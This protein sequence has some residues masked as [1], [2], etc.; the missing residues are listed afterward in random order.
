M[1]IPVAEWSAF[2]LWSP[3]ERGGYFF[4]YRIR[5]IEFQ[6]PNIKYRIELLGFD[7]RVEIIFGC[8][9]WYRVELIA[10]QISIG[11]VA[12]FP[13]TGQ[14]LAPGFFYS[15]RPPVQYHRSSWDEGI[16]RWGV[17]TAA[18]ILIKIIIVSWTKESYCCCMLLLLW[19]YITVLGKILTGC[20]HRRGLLV[21]I[22]TWLRLVLAWDYFYRTLVWARPTLVNFHRRCSSTTS[23]RPIL[24]T[25]SRML[26]SLVFFFDVHRKWSKNSI[27][28]EERIPNLHTHTQG[29]AWRG[30]SRITG[31]AVFRCQSIGD[32]MKCIPGGIIKF[33]RGKK[34]L[35]DGRIIWASWQE[36]ST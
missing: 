15:L 22:L 31:G 26:F 21:V 24:L 9:K 35:P 23:F 17:S 18:N 1:I 5:H 32:G 27:E 29:L 28:R 20:G 16:G 6:P 2:R 10:V 19:Y 30:M 14:M 13:P 3:G 4:Q 8:R 7:C 12:L 34:R 11:V 25:H 36:C 33:L